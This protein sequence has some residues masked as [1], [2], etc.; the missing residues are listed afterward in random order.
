M[1]FPISG[2]EVP[3]LIILSIGFTVGVMSGFLGVGGGWIITPA[4]YIF[5]FP[6]AFAVGSSIAQIAGSAAAATVRHR[7]LG[8]ID[9]KLGILMVF[10]M[11]FGVEVGVQII[12][13]LK[14]I[15]GVDVIIGLTLIVFMSITSIYVLRETL[16]TK[17]L[18]KSGGKSEAF[19][20]K[21]AQKVQ[22]FHLPPMVSFPKSKIKAI[23]IWFIIA[24]SLTTGLLS[25]TIGVGGGFIIVPMLYY[26]VGCSTT[27]AVGT[28]LFSIIFA[29][30]Y[31]AISHGLRGNVDIVV[32]LI[33]LL[34]ASVGAQI[35]SQATKYVKGQS[36]RLIFGACLAAAALAQ[37]LKL[38]GL[39][40]VASVVI[41]GT[42]IATSGLI[43][44]LLIKSMK[45]L[46]H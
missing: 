28:S 36:I 46:Q 13:F 14:S 29:S 30:G 4:L 33:M 18:A 9:T 41:L 24:I 21:F 6:M 45:K 32:A 27:I 7:K 1:Q 43:I 40:D 17:K 37:G 3:L 10:G 39:G 2:S 31:G 23:S 38:S 20:L 12:Q 35:G 42:A 25:A 16:K 8:N 19:S 44:I 5:G 26:W 22:G 15:G 11:I 34:T